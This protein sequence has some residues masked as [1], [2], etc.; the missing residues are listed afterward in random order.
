[1][2]HT[3]LRSGTATAIQN[4]GSIEV[5]T[6]TRRISKRLQERASKSI[7]PK[8]ASDPSKSPTS[9]TPKSKRSKPTPKSTSNS[10]SPKT[11]PPRSPTS[12]SFEN[13]DQICNC[14]N[15]NSDFYAKW[16]HTKQ[17]CPTNLRSGCTL[18]TSTHL[19]LSNLTDLF[20]HEP[21]EL[22]HEV[23]RSFSHGEK[24]REEFDA[25]IQEF[26]EWNSTRRPQILSTN[27][28]NM[29]TATLQ[30][31]FELFN[32]IFFLQSLRGTRV[33][34]YT[35]RRIMGRHLGLT[36]PFP[37]IDPSKGER[38]NNIS[39]LPIITCYINPPN[40]IDELRMI[41]ETEGKQSPKRRTNT[42]R[43]KKRKVLATWV[44]NKSMKEA[45]ATKPTHIGKEN[46]AGVA[47]GA[48]QSARDP[49]GRTGKHHSPKDDQSQKDQMY[50]PVNFIIGTLLH[51]M[52]HAF[53]WLFICRGTT[54][55]YPECGLNNE[56]QS[57]R[58]AYICGWNLGFHGHGRVWRRLATAIEQKAETLLGI[59]TRLIA[60][61]DLTDELEESSGW[62]PSN[63][64]I[65]EFFKDD[66]ESKDAIINA[67]R[68]R[69]VMIYATKGKSK[70]SENSNGREI[71]EAKQGGI[72]QAKIAAKFQE[73]NNNDSEFYFNKNLLSQCNVQTNID[74]R[75]DTAIQ[76]NAG[77]L[78]EGRN[79]VETQPQNED[80]P[81]LTTRG[82]RRRLNIGGTSITTH[83]FLEAF[84]TDFEDNDAEWV[85]DHTDL[86]VYRYMC[87]IK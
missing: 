37:R 31:L 85:D 45:R 73:L 4:N 53:L 26:K 3:T 1:M 62:L 63:C 84:D 78:I 41:K 25:A 80:W 5:S 12:P 87:L 18:R 61:R 40:I 8:R 28:E 81:E 7:S 74:K 34:R 77:V 70:A 64:D 58:C 46:V 36:P 86:A 49:R 10:S 20:Y 72:T 24:K 50:D 55:P 76:P 30:Y 22:I 71:P 54:T 38:N 15:C 65:R 17:A 39:R 6:S 43:T 75:A 19:P 67:R 35:N 9:G 11:S 59:K 13:L 51:E 2:S 60:P 69:K 29:S 27:P 23:I 68:K 47:N 57:N 83:T 66:Q 33:I 56:C 16:P 82:K 42:S 14:K 48:H 52:A 21:N 44:E 79:D 32:S